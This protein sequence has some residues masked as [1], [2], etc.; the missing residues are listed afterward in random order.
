MCIFPLIFS[1]IALKDGSSGN[2]MCLKKKYRSHRRLCGSSGTWILP[3]NRMFAKERNSKFLK[4]TSSS[5]NSMCL[6]LDTV[7]MV[8]WPTTVGFKLSQW[9][10]RV[11]VIVRAR[12]GEGGPFGRA[13]VFL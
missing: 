5:G 3:W 1:K 2:S 4:I 6:E 13:G 7:Y 9:E 10:Y 12:L 8:T 11:G